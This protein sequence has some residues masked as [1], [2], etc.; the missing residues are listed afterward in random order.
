MSAEDAVG[1]AANG[2][3]VVVL[4]MSVSRL[5]HR[6]DV[7]HRPVS[8]PEPTTVAL[9]WLREADSDVHQDFVG[10]VRGR[11]PSSSR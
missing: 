10:V 4:P 5:H 3:G 11:R 2:A 6:K 9:L 7:V 8:G 1:L